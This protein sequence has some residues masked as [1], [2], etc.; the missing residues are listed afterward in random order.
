MP[1]PIQGVNLAAPVGV[2][3][4]VQSGSAPASAP[5]DTAPVPASPQLDQADV[6]NTEA[7]LE[8]IGQAAGNVAVVDQAKVAGLRQALAAG[9]FQANPERIAQKIIDLEAALTATGG[10][11]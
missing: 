3:S 8:L 1:D 5:A 11:G 7:L 4:T 10:I 2:A 9:S 6:R